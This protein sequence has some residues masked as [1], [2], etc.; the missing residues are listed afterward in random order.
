MDLFFY[1]S[2][3]SGEECHQ[4]FFGKRFEAALFFGSFLLGK[5]KNPSEAELGKTK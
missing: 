2:P 3:L 1:K 5:Q 4:I